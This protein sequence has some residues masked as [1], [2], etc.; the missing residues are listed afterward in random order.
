MIIFFHG[1]D[2]DPDEEVKIMLKRKIITAFLI[3]ASVISIQSAAF[4][5]DEIA[6]GTYVRL[7]TYN[8]EPIVWK[9]IDIDDENGILMLSDKILCYK[10]FDIGDDFEGGS[11]EYGDGFWETSTIRTW[12]NSRETAGNIVWPEHKNPG[13]QFINGPYLP[14]DQEDG[15]ISENNFTESELNAIK[16]VSQWQILT[17]DR[18]DMSTNG[19]YHTFQMHELYYGD[20]RTGGGRSA[21]YADVDDLSHVEGAMYR[22]N[23]TIFLLDVRQAYRLWSNFGTVEAFP[24]DAALSSVS[25]NTEYIEYDNQSRYCLR[26]PTG[27]ITYVYGE[28]G[29]DC[30]L[31]GYCY[32]IRPAFYLNEKN[33]QILSGSGTEADPYVIDG[34]FTQTSAAVF[35][36]GE[37]LEFDQEPINDSGRLLV[38]ARAIFE[39][40][41]AEVEYDE[42]TET[43]TANDGERTVVMQIDNP[44]MGN[45]TEVFELE[46][47]PQIVNGRTMVPLRAVSEAFDCSVEY[48]ES[49]NRVVID[50]PELPM[51]FGEGVGI[52]DWQQDWY[53]EIYGD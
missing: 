15:F 44:E 22:L 16:S 35:S 8:D 30:F 50:K 36:Q 29:Y 40:L 41:G 43:V 20:G 24:T 52:E 31:A 39:S 13:R 42:S 17:E 3:I 4:A 5:S 32:G 10:A 11:Y 46:V 27:G 34:K 45:G 18:V 33:Y 2:D 38:P 28:K 19:V 26:T 14:Y 9:C 6:V 7:G 47:S 51:D 37:Q 23:D 25:N 49:L 1:G 48:V 21:M 53:K 12:L